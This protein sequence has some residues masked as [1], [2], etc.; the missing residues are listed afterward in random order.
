MLSKI[1]S[2]LQKLIKK[3]NN[4]DFKIT[5]TGSYSDFKIKLEENILQINI[6]RYII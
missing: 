6:V 2:P 4:I 1:I 3:E 5:L